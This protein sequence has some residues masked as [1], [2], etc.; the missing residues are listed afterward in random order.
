MHPWA[1]NPSHKI[2]WLGLEWANRMEHFA[3]GVDCFYPLIHWH[4]FNFQ[5]VGVKHANHVVC[6]Q[7]FFKKIVHWLLASF[8]LPIIFRVFV[9]SRVLCPILLSGFTLVASSK[10]W[11]SVL[12][13]P[14]LSMI[15]D[16]PRQ[17]NTLVMTT[18][19][20]CGEFRNLRGATAYGFHK[21]LH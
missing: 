15:L 6:I 13:W 17:L 2:D 3:H 21:P 7:G 10:R 14:K 19:C 20:K 16:G 4:G 9:S 5:A 8:R 18:L 1:F 11:R 12:M